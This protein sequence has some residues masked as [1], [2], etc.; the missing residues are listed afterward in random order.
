ML[1]EEF[2]AVAE[3]ICLTKL[4]KGSLISRAKIIATGLPPF[5]QTGQ[6]LVPASGPVTCNGLNGVGLFPSWGPD[7]RSSEARTLPTSSAIARDE[8]SAMRDFIVKQASVSK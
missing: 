5:C 6:F 7:F 2:L 1:Q 4:V 8:P 3:S